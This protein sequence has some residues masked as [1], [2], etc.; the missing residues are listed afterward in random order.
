[1]G[2]DHSTLLKGHAADYALLTQKKL[3]GSQCVLQS[4]LIQKVFMPSQLYKGK[5]NLNDFL[6]SSGTIPARTSTSGAVGETALGPNLRASKEVAPQSFNATKRSEIELRTEK[7]C[8]VNG[9]MVA[10]TLG[11]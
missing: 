8:I 2:A 11:E 7:S 5:I 3:I 9:E 4:G 6:K 10:R 1:M